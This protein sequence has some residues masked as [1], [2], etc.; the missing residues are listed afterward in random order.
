MWVF[1]YN[2]NEHNLPFLHAYIGANMYSS[3]LIFLYS[4]KL[5]TIAAGTAFL[6]ND[7]IKKLMK[8]QSVS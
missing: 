8:T 7:L 6:G 4:G 1:R 2:F 3:N 5:N